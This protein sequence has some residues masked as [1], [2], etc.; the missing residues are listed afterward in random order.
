MTSLLSPSQVAALYFIFLDRNKGAEKRAPKKLVWGQEMTRP[1]SVNLFLSPSSILAVQ[2]VDTILQTTIFRG[3]KWVFL[4][5]PWFDSC[6]SFALWRL[7]RASGGQKVNINPLLIFLSSYKEPPIF[8]QRPPYENY[9]R[10]PRAMS[11]VFFRF[12]CFPNLTAFRAEI[13]NWSSR[14]RLARA[15]SFIIEKEPFPPLSTF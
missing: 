8:P 10:S 12:H 1:G 2:S 5:C 14:L 4:F 6:D 11:K 13:I 15:G 3:R 7:R 9:F